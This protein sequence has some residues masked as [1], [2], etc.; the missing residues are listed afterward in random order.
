[1]VENSVVVS[2]TNGIEE[3]RSKEYACEVKKVKWEFYCLVA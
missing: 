1:M 2:P 3:E